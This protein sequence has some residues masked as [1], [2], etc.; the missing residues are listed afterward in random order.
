MGVILIKH[1]AKMK[2]V[3]VLS[4]GVALAASFTVK[5]RAGSDADYSGDYSGG[6]DYDMRVGSDYSGYDYGEFSGFSGSD[7]SG[8]DFSGSDRSGSD[9]SGSDYYYYGS[10]FDYSGDYDDFLTEM[11]SGSD[12]FG[13][14]FSGFDYSGSDFSG[15]DFPFSRSDRS[16]SDFSGSDYYYYGSGFDYSGDYDDFLTEMRSG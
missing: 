3:L 13:S 2:V 1:Q 11:R 10:G 9:F 16:G 12:F 14:D 5:S 15:S 7:F 6:S 8:S 4:I